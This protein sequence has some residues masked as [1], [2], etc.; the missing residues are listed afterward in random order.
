MHCRFQGKSQSVSNRSL[1]RSLLVSRLL[2]MAMT[3]RMPL[4]LMSSP[5]PLRKQQEWFCYRPQLLY[6][7]TTAVLFADSCFLGTRPIC[8]GLAMVLIMLV[9]MV[10]YPP[11]RDALMLLAS[12]VQSMLVYGVYPM[13][14]C[15][16]SGMQSNT[17][18]I[19]CWLGLIP[20]GHL[21]IRSCSHAPSSHGPS[22][23]LNVIKATLSC[24][25][26]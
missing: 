10:Q 25:Y 1:P 19:A 5:S 6:P 12:L 24:C 11:W 7:T 9:L 8:S 20:R 21:G 22:S 23:F 13:R 14:L 26:C 18:T 16:T 4:S 3:T 15:N 17:T 2:L